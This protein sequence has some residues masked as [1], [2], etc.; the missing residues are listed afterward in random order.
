LSRVEF[1]HSGRQSITPYKAYREESAG[2]L[3]HFGLRPWC[4]LGRSQSEGP[5]PDEGHSPGINLA[6]VGGA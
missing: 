5:S 1:F 4:G 6:A 3:L 2:C